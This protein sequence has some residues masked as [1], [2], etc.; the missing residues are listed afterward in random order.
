MSRNYWG[1]RID[2]DFS[3]ELN[4]EL[5]Q[6]RLRQ[7]WGYNQGQDLRNFTYD[8]GAGRNYP[9]LNNVKKGDL[10]LVPHLPEWGRVT[11][12]EATDDWDKGYQFEIFETGDHGHIF[13]AKPLKIFGRHNENVTGNLR[14]T[15]R[16]PGR[17]WN[18]NHYSEDIEQLLSAEGACIEGQD[19]LVRLRMSVDKML[20]PAKPELMKHLRNQF[21]GSEWENVL[22]EVFKELYP[23][24]S[25]ERVGGVTESEHGTDILITIPGIV[26]GS[27]YG[28]AVQVKDYDG[29]TGGHP[30]DQV[31]KADWLARDGR[32]II[33]K[34]VA[35][36]GSSSEDNQALADYARV[37]GVKILFSRDVEKLLFA[38]ACRVIGQGD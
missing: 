7:G 35:L 12:A 1:F 18:I 32:M 28:I 30:V 3:K 20:T 19:Q 16:N 36:T 37:K 2:R 4:E 38:Y 33:E 17:F 10:L 24:G 23:K 5:C 15:L 21:T 9:M 26:P 25:V 14:S 27:S 22:V 13:P 34:I 8:E 11:I 31:L 29:T 6:G